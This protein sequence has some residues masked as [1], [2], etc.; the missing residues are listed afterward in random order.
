MI[1]MDSI[2]RTICQ[3]FGLRKSDLVGTDKHVGLV[4]PRHIAMYLCSTLTEQ[5]LP[6][7]SHRFGGRDHTTVLY[8]TNKITDLRQSDPALDAELKYLE[9]AIVTRATAV[10]WRSIDSLREG[11]SHMSLR[12]AR[13]ARTDVQLRIQQVFGAGVNVIDAKETLRLQPTPVDCV[14]ADAKAPDNCILVHTANRMYGSKAALFWKGYAYL[15]LITPEDGIVRVHRFRLSPGAFQH[16]DDLD[17]GKPF[18][19][20]T[21]VLLHAPSPS[22]T[23]PRKRKSSRQWTR[24][25]S[26]KA[27]RKLSNARRALAEAKAAVSQ[28]ENIISQTK[29]SSTIASVQAKERRQRLNQA[30]EKVTRLSQEF[31]EVCRAPG[32][33]K[34]R[35]ARRF[36]LTTRN[37]AAGAYNFVH[38]EG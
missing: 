23:L 10:E 32:G 4:I 6:R 29:S 19:E 35:K 12:K 31:E 25:A 16:I 5:S 30:R 1:L 18:H 20:G 24:T 27:S 14:G 17:T 34:P 26:G 3:R 28:F 36:D 21:A 13:S 22:E 7:I 37:G 38:N 9:N 33:P 11:Y 15:D 2:Q 8:A